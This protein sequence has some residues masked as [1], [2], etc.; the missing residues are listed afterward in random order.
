MLTYILD[1]KTAD[2]FLKNAIFLT[3]TLLGLWKGK[4]IGLEDNDTPVFGGK[5]CKQ[6]WP[7]IYLMSSTSFGKDMMQV[8]QA[9]WQ[10]ISCE[11]TLQYQV[12][13]F[14][15]QAESKQNCMD[16]NWS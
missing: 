8:L 12:K 14:T 6:G 3:S 16:L 13:Y 9:F 4:R 11:W 2:S 15:C 5:S 10:E 1:I 7:S